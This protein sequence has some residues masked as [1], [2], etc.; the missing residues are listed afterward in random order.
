[1]A[2]GILGVI[3]LRPPSRSVL[4]IGYGILGPQVVT[5]LLG[6]G[7]HLAPLW[8]TDAVQAGRWDTLRY[9]APVFAPL[10]FVDLAVLGALGRW[11]LHPKL[12]RSR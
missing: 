10:L 3:V 11:D 4:L 12:E 1:M 9:G 2:V 8:T 7:L 6:L 5:G